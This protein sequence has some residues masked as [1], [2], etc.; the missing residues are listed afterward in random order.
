MILRICRDG[1][2]LDPGWVGSR[3][4]VHN[5]LAVGSTAMAL[6]RVVGMTLRLGPG[7]KMT[8]PSIGLIRAVIVPGPVVVLGTLVIPRPVVV[9]RTLV[10]PRPVIVPRTLVIPRPVIVPRLRRVVA[11]CVIVIEPGSLVASLG[12]LLMPVT[13]AVGEGPTQV[14]VRRACTSMRL[15]HIPQQFRGDALAASNV[16]VRKS[17]GSH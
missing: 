15:G 13:G 16:Q 9:P 8:R 11:R 2:V 6:F 3:L 14:S 1:V 4:P 10:I 17:F 12:V 5:G 7:L